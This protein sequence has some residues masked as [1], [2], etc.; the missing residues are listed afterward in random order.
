MITLQ[1]FLHIDEYPPDANQGFDIPSTVIGFPD[2]VATIN[3]SRENSSKISPL[4]ST[5]QVQLVEPVDY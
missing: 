5:F 4:S 1:A 3:Y 2:F